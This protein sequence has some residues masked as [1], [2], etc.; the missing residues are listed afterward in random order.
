MRVTARESVCVREIEVAFAQKDANYL[1][2]WNC[3]VAD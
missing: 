1:V 3:E 2:V